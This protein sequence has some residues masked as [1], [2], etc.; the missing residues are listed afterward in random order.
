MMYEVEG[1]PGAEILRRLPQQPEA[2]SAQ[3]SPPMMS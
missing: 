3:Q 1:V 2:A